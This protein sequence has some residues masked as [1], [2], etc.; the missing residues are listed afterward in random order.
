MI[1]RQQLKAEFFTGI[2]LQKDAP[3]CW[4]YTKHIKKNG[5]GVIF[6]DG[7]KI[8]AHKY[9]FEL[10]KGPLMP[11]KHI[12]HSCGVRNCCCPGHMV[13]IWPK[14]HPI[15]HARRG[16]YKGENNRNAK[17]SNATIA[18]FKSLASMGFTAKKLAEI[19]KMSPSHS[20]AICR[21]R[22]RKVC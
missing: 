22:L 11:G 8:Y 21:G 2:E 13:D 12:H 5:Y 4:L 3:F 7:L 6:K 20:R 14:Q 17:F 1:N 15:I 10:Y 16:I 9:A 19:F 18:S